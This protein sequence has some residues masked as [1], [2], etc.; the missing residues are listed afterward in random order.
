MNLQNARQHIIHSLNALYSEN[1]IRNFYFLIIENITALRHEQILADKSTELSKAQCE[2]LHTIVNRL[3]NFEPIQ[4][5]LGKTV[6][7]R[8]PFEVNKQV[9]IPRPET[10]ELVDWILHETQ[11]NPDPKIMDIGTG[12]GCIAIALAK[13]KPQ[14]QVQAIDISDEA[15]HVALQNAELN[16][17]TV[18][19]KKTDALSEDF[20]QIKKNEFDIIVSN[21]PYICDSERKSMD[22]NVLDYEPNLALFVSDSDP[23]IFYRQIALFAKNNLTGNGLLFFEINQALG[24][25]TVSL[26]S[27][28]G[29][30]NIILRKD[31]FGNNRMIK[32]CLL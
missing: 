2:N 27:Q 30:K 1:E 26:L 15:L 9:L 5:I 23:L 7:Y 13:N 12:S 29:F 20:L 28:I 11:D 22:S 16:K 19:F 14:A 10:E 32:A 3:A 21:P 8:L 31:F 6:F 25:Q 4:Y 24:N 17:V 18:D